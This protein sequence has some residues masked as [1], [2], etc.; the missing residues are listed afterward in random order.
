[1]SLFE[2]ENTL[3][4]LSKMSNPFAERKMKGNN[5]ENDIQILGKNKFIERVSR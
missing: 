3:E 5:M 1:M 4:S 2:Q